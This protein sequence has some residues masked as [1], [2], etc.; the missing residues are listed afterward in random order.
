[1]DYDVWGR[2]TLD[3]NPGFQP[4]GFAGGLYDKDTGLVRFGARDYDPETGRWTAKDPILFGGGDANLYAYVG[5]NPVS[6][7]DPLGFETTLITTYDYGIGSHSGLY[8]VTP[9]KEPF[10]YDPAGGY[11]PPPPAERGSG[12]IFEGSE[13]DLD[14]YLKYHKEE[15]STVELIKL[16]TTPDQEQAIKDRANI[17]RHYQKQ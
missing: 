9:G 10:L 11:E 5:G 2:V 8:I 16:P 3:T 15:G 4:F 7:I 12:G 13:A 6:K 1:M 14:R 17:I